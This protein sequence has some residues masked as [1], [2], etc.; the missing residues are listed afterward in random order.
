MSTF[1]ERLKEERKRLGLNQTDFAGIG[2]VTKETQIKYENGTRKPD[3]EYL[4]AI[5]KNGVDVAYLISG[6]RGTTRLSQPESDLLT[7][8]QALD[9]R[10]KSGVL[11]LL[12]GIAPVK[13][14]P[15]AI[16]HG[17]VGQVVQNDVTAPQ[18]FNFGVKQPK[19]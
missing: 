16:F 1:F 5:F 10:G 15:T 19:K 7:A 9:E 13:Q 8:F 6:I 11:A 3:S 4:E 17:D 14:A 12:K 18:T 2:S